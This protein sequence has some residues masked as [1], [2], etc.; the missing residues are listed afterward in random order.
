MR[1]RIPHPNQ[2]AET[3]TEGGGER[4]RKFY[5]PKVLGSPVVLCSGRVTRHEEMINSEVDGCSS[6]SL[7][8]LEPLS[9][10]PL[11][12]TPAS[13]AADVG[14][15]AQRFLQLRAQGRCAHATNASLKRR[16]TETDASAVRPHL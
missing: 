11:D 15:G 3:E 5:R 4:R 2:S 10:Q 6:T 12:Y 16:K 9:S 1:D 14:K 7:Q 13:D 8:P